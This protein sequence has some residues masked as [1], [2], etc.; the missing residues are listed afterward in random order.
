MDRSEGRPKAIDRYSE[1]L[2]WSQIV[3]SK[4]VTKVQCVR[5]LESA[6]SA[7]LDGLLWVMDIE[8]RCEVAAHSDD[9]VVLSGADVRAC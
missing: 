5:E 8:R 2:L 9:S 1:E 7:S 3:H 4:W 6:V